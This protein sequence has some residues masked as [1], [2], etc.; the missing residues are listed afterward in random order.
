MFTSFP[1]YFFAEGNVCRLPVDVYT[2]NKLSQM[3]IYDPRSQKIPVPPC[4]HLSCCCADGI[5]ATWQ[6]FMH[7]CA[8]VLARP[9]YTYIS[10]NLIPFLSTLWEWM[11]TLC[12]LVSRAFV[13]SELKEHYCAIPQFSTILFSI[14]YEPTCVPTSLS[15]SLCIKCAGK[16][17]SL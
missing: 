10:A 7:T 6:T 8:H 9:V 15:L 13:G 12:L 3:K 16:G 5:T 1:F 2:E 14:L 11:G 4:L 17:S